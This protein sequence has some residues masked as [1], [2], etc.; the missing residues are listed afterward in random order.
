[1]L[2]VKDEGIILK[3]THL[4]FENEA[5]LNPACIEIGGITHMFYRAVKKGN[6]SS[7]GYCQLQDNQVIK[8]Y[9]HPVIAPEFE[10]EQHGTED[11]RV[12]KLDNLYYLFYTA[13]DGKNA[14]VAYATSHDLV[15]FEKKGLIT[16]SIT[17]D[18]AE[19]I[20]RSGKLQERYFLFES[21]YKEKHGKDVLLWEKDAFLLPKK[22]NNQFCL[23]HRIL[24]GIQLIYFNDFKDL[25]EEYWIEYLKN[26]DKYV[27]LDPKKWFEIRNIGGGCPPVEVDEGWLLIYHAVEDTSKGKVYHAAAALLDKNDPLKVIGK[28]PYPMFSPT[29]QWEKEG[30]VND[31]VF[32]TGTIVKD[33]KI[34]VYYGAADQLIAAKTFDLKELISEIQKANI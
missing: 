21:Y 20:F 16:P 10:Y 7:I 23:F 30:T 8:R 9:D 32:P 3:K 14:R 13:Y 29:E 1:M 11:P 22:I 5:V 18:K 12:I 2:E 28:L 19:D 4:E 15:T 27:V 17:Y 6:Y 31:V 26:L 25:T 24:P 34:T 33:G